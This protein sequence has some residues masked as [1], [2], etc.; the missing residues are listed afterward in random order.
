MFFGLV[1]ITV[2]ILALLIKLG[3]ISGSLWGY[4]WPIILILL[5]L[6]FLLGRHRM[7]TWRRHWWPIDEG[8]KQ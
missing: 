5:G 3:V 6:S 1:L 7:R 8:P 4:A 2:G